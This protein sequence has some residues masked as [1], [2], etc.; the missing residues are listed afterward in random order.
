MKK[1]RKGSRARFSVPPTAQPSTDETSV[2][3]CGAPAN[4]KHKDRCRR[5]H[6]LKDNTLSL[7]H[8]ARSRRV[9]HAGLP[10]QAE[11]RALLQEKEAGLVA[12]LGGAANVGVAKRELTTRFVETSAIL[13]F[14][15]GNILKFGVL[16]TKGRQR[17]A[18]ATYLQVLDRITRLALALG[19]ERQAKQVPSIEDFLRQ[20]QQPPQEQEPA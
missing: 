9:M 18:V 20:R 13:S 19:L 12:D 10:E 11:L 14:L 3:R 17:A 6:P 4:P 16:T 7:I 5:G 1:K 15:G 2:C 8:G